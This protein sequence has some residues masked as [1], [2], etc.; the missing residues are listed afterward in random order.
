MTPLLTAPM[1]V[2]GVLAVNVFICEWLCRRTWLRHLGTALLVI[3]LTAVEANLGWIPTYGEDV[4]VYTATFSYLVPLSVFWLLLDV[5]L[6]RI[7][8]AGLPMIGLFLAGSIGVALGVIVGMWV[9]DGPEAFGDFYAPLGGMFVGTYT[10]GSVNFAAIATHYEVRDNALLFLGA[11]AVD[12]AM[13][14]VWMAACV[15]LPRLL[16]PLWPATRRGGAVGDHESLVEDERASPADLGLVFGLGLLAVWSADHIA[17]YLNARFDWSLP[18]ILVTTTLALVAAQFGLGRRMRG[19]RAMGLFTI[20][21]FLAVIGAL[22]DLKAVEELGQMAFDL[23]LF[24]A[25]ILAIHGLVI[26]GTA[27]LFRIDPETAAVASQAGVGGG[28]S[29]LALAKSL[30]RSD[31]VVPGILAGS[32]GTALGTFLGF[33][34]VRLLG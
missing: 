3:V 19:A 29:A 16:R 34:V 12:A 26:Y 2:A 6:R 30:G 9:V 18:S 1:A 25:V 10:G 21:V 24:V 27:A 28:S 13:T 15:L 8:D 17:G 20:Y 11:N 23:T 5:D 4:L 32:L 7:L 22:C 31:L 14:T 33:E